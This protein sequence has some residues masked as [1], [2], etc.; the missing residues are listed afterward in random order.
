MPLIKTI[1]RTTTVEHLCS[2]NAAPRKFKRANQPNTGSFTPISL[3]I[4]SRRFLQYVQPY[5]RYRHFEHPRGGIFLLRDL[6]AAGGGGG[7]GGGGRA[8]AGLFMIAA[9][10]AAGLCMTALLVFF[11]VSG[12]AAGSW[13]AMASHL[14]FFFPTSRLNKLWNIDEAK[15]VA[16]GSPIFPSPSCLGLPSFF[17]FF[18]FPIVLC[19]GCSAIGTPPASAK[20]S[21]LLFFFLL[22]LFRRGFHRCSRRLGHPGDTI[23]NR[24]LGRRLGRPVGNYRAAFHIVKLRKWRFTIH[25][26]SW[27]CGS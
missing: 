27:S 13:A 9:G 21:I 2:V 20:P 22:P 14:I 11:P 16:S 5:L 15:A 24:W 3:M 17:F 1:T 18:F 7:G 19:T 26:S 10:A 4:L 12:L 23:A 6:A 25:D 8:V